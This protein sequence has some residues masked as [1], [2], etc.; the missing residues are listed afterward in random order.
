MRRVT[1]PEEVHNYVRKLIENDAGR[2]TTRNK[3]S[4]M[5]AGNAPFSQK[6][7]RAAGQG[8]RCNTNFDEARSIIKSRNASLYEL[9]FDSRYYIE[10][11]L[12][13]GQ[14]YHGHAYLWEN[15]MKEEITRLL[16]SW[17]EHLF[18]MM[19][20]IDSMH[21]W[22]SGF[23]CW[24]N[25]VD[26][27]P[28]AFNTGD[29]LF[30]QN[31]K[32][33]VGYIDSF[34]M[35]DEMSVP[36]LTQMLSEAGADSGWQTAN[37]E[38]AIKSAVEKTSSNYDSHNWEELQRDI[39]NS[40]L[41]YED[42]LIGSIK[43][44]HMFVEESDGMIS[45]YIVQRGKDCSG[46]LYKKNDAYD[47]FE[48]IVTPLVCDIGNGYYHSL[49]GIGHRIYSAVLVNNR[50]LCKIVDGAM[51]S[52][53]MV[54]G[55]R[56]GT[57]RKS[58]S[59]RIGNE[60]LL[61][62]GA[63]IEQSQIQRNLQSVTNVYS[64]INQVNQSNV[65]IQRPGISTLAHDDKAQHTARGESI[66]AMKEAKL[67][68]MD[69]NLY[70]SQ[71]DSFYE[72]L[73]TRIFKS[74]EG[75]AV[76]FKARLLSRGMPE[77]LMNPYLWTFKS[78][79]LIGS[80]SQVMKHLITSELLSIAPHLP[81]MGQRELIAD[82]LEARVAPENVRR[83]LPTFDMD[84]MP[85]SSHQIAQLENNDLKQ[86]QNCLVGM[87]NWHVTHCKVHLSF[88]T[89]FAQQVIQQQDPASLGP[90]MNAFQVA[91]DHM[92]IHL[93]Y[94]QGDKLHASELPALLGQYKELLA[95]VQVIDKANQSFMKQQE[96][97]AQ[98]QAAAQ[99][100]MNQRGDSVELQKELA[101]IQSD[102]EMRIYKENQNNEV[103][104]AKAQHG[105]MID[106]AVAQNEIAIAQAKANQNQ[107]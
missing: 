12:I 7:Q 71:M 79:R 42:E 47:A 93:N 61:P 69:V 105:M 27:K 5:I 43:V 6:K 62:P 44:A 96:Q 82:Y 8:Q 76:G 55:F 67:E 92:G 87:D 66:A 54:L 24:T 90:A 49:K 53:A 107:G 14:S 37:V 21:K 11:R 63:S 48:Q 46:F 70:Y 98:E 23:L 52:T 74:E 99:E 56:D 68:S 41:G 89:S 30:P 84:S 94:L 3:V 38:K 83:Y 78:P 9:F 60:I 75:D 18:E 32:A 20:A 1:K 28:T 97:M 86:G 22:G 13:D 59:L 35:L 2:A 72:Q 58:R 31:T 19:S 17:P 101:K 25:S 102:Q 81:E 95:Q 106:E 29:I 26:W 91:I 77:E 36:D 40:S 104:V 57:S 65:G 39:E 50:F 73:V 85:T 80:G 34:A 4:G 16:N 103:R 45:H 100:E 15:M 10:A 64:M 51:D 33:S 88:F